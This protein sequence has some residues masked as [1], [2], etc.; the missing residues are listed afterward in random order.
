MFAQVVAQGRKGQPKLAITAFHRCAQP[1]SKKPPRHV[2][3]CPAIAHQ[4]QT[5]IRTT[6]GANTNAQQIRVQSFAAIRYI[7]ITF[8]FG[9]FVPERWQKGMDVWCQT[10]WKVIGK[11]EWQDSNFHFLF[12]IFFKASRSS[13]DIGDLL[14]AF[15]TKTPGISNFKA[16]STA[17]L[18]AS[19]VT[20]PVKSLLS[21]I[22]FSNSS[23]NEISF[24]PFLFCG[25]DS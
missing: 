5:H 9:L 12:F 18:V 8:Q 14:I 15:L 6:F 11:I 17:F 13:S 1:K 4:A 7:C 25:R 24:S 16:C 10:A 21:S 19:S 3:L 20:L 2:I 22:I 23:N